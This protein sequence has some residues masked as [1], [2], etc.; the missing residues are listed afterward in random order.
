MK[1]RTITLTLTPSDDQA[2]VSFTVWVDAKPQAQDTI[3]LDHLFLTVQDVLNNTL[4][5]VCQQV[6]AQAKA[7]KG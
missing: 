2:R 3:Y 4:Q 6:N 7:K 5:R 1:E